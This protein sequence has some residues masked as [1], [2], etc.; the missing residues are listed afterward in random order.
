MKFETKY[1]LILHKTYFDKGYAL[2][3]YF[4]YLLA[5]FGLTTLD[6]NSTMT[7]AFFYAIACYWIGRWWFKYKWVS[8]AH[9]V[10]NRINPFV[11]E[12]RKSINGKV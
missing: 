11:K 6:L 4:T 10:D 8:A 3:K 5:L 7:I 12:M 1:R 9:E 2:T